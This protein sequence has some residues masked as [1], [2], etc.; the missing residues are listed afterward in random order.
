MWRS[1]DATLN[2]TDG[3]AVVISQME[4]IY[5]SDWVLSDGS[6]DEVMDGS[7]NLQHVLTQAIDLKYIE[8]VT[9]GGATDPF[10]GR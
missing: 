10:V 6:I 1:A 7:F 3:T 8:S 4:S 2:Y 5:A 9:I